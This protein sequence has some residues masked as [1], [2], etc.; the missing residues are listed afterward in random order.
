MNKYVN[1]VCAVL[2]AF[3][4]N[5]NE[6]NDKITAEIIRSTILTTYSKN[7][8]IDFNDLLEDYQTCLYLFKGTII[9][10]IPSFEDSESLN[11][12]LELKSQIKKT[13]LNFEE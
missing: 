7:R 5:E 13:L 4:L 8:E 11:L 6:S 12:Y 1:M 3:I 10:G 2:N 9:L